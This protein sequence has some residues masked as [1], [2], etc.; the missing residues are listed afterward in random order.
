MR[1]IFVIF[2]A[3]IQ[4]LQ[5]EKRRRLIERRSVCRKRETELKEGERG[6]ESE[7]QERER[8]RDGVN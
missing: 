7:W 2:Q 6:G 8:E 4:T 3:L 1:P 5:V